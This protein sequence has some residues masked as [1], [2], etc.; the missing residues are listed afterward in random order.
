MA[1]IKVRQTKLSKKR[2][3]ILPQRLESLP[4]LPPLELP[5]TLVPKRTLPSIKR[6]SK[7]LKRSK[8]TSQLVQSPKPKLSVKTGY[9]SDPDVHLKDS[10]E[11]FND[12]ELK[13]E[14]IESTEDNVDGID[15]VPEEQFEKVKTPDSGFQKDEVVS[16]TTSDDME[17]HIGNGVQTVQAYLGIEPENKCESAKSKGRIKNLI[18]E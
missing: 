14:D 4:K 12:P 16:E 11:P 5:P 8:S 3:Q 10:S 7:E 18:K 1:T 15:Q 6:V 13:I 17:A 9:E 2:L